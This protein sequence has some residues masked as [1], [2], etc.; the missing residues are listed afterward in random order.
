MS[1]CC[2]TDYSTKG[3]WA[4]LQ[5]KVNPVPP[6]LHVFSLCTNLNLILHLV[7][8]ADKITLFGLSDCYA[9]SDF[10]REFVTPRMTGPSAE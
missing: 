7:L 6:A 9:A 8:N 10:T 5:I 1:I 4:G 2:A 3:F